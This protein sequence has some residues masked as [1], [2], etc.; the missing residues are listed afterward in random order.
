MPSAS[1]KSISL[2]LLRLDKLQIYPSFHLYKSWTSLWHHAYSRHVCACTCLINTF[3]DVIL[4]CVISLLRSAPSDVT[5]LTLTPWL[6]PPLHGLSSTSCPKSYECFLLFLEGDPVSCGC[7]ETPVEPEKKKKKRRKADEADQEQ[8]EDH[9][10]SLVVYSIFLRPPLA[11]LPLPSFPSAS[12]SPR[13]VL[14]HASLVALVETADPSCISAAAQPHP[15]GT[16]YPYDT[17]P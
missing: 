15:V 3:I 14:F 7:P 6:L 17:W 8:S 16:R 5:I 13:A 11:P 4:A 1:G 9:L 2:N 10:L 12:P